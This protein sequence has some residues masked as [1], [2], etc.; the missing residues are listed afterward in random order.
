MYTFLARNVI[1]RILDWSF[2]TRCT[3]M[4]SPSRRRASAKGKVK[5]YYV[6]DRIQRNNI[7]IQS[8][9]NKSFRNLILGT[10]KAALKSF[11]EHLDYNEGKSIIAFLSRESSC[12]M[13]DSIK[14]FGK[15]LK[16]FARSAK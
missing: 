11:R 8:Y 14:C 9:Q 5:L 2:P 7:P 16:Y 13:V 3:W 15:R 4:T 6:R 1:I 10:V 12:F